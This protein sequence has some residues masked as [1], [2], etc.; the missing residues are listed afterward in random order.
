MPR[1]V[2]AL[3][4]LLVLCHIGAGADFAAPR[5]FE[6]R[7]SALLADADARATTLLQD[8]MRGALRPGRDRRETADWGSAA[9]LHRIM[10]L[11]QPMAQGMVH[12][13]LAAEMAQANFSSL[14]HSDPFFREAASDARLQRMAR[15]Q[16]TQHCKDVRKEKSCSKVQKMLRKYLPEF[17]LSKHH[18][19]SGA[20]NNLKHR[21]YGSTPMPL[22]R[23]LGAAYDQPESSP[24]STGAGGQPLPGSR[25][26]SNSLCFGSQDQDQI[27]TMMGVTWGQL[28]DHDVD[29]TCAGNFD[30]NQSCSG[31][32]GSS[33]ETKACFPIAVATSDT[34]LGCRAGNCIPMARSCPAC[35]KGQGSREQINQ[36][37]SYHDASNV[38]GGPFGA[39]DTY[40]KGLADLTTGKMRVQ[41]SSSN[42]DLLPQATGNP[43]SCDGTCFQGGDAR[44]NEVPVLTAFH[45]IWVR[46]HN[47]L[48]PALK[49]INPT[50]TP[51]K[52][53]LE[54]R[55]IVTALHQ[56][57]TYAEFVPLLLGSPLESYKYCPETDASTANVFATASFR[58]AHSAI[59][60]NFNLADDQYM[61]LTPLSVVD[62][63]FDTTHIRSPGALDNLL[64]G[65]A[66]Q[67]AFKV[68]TKFSDSL[69]NRMFESSH[70]DC[71]LDLLS[72]N[73]QR[74]RDHGLPSYN[75]WRQLV[76]GRC[77]LT[78]GTVHSFDDLKSE[79]S[80]QSLASLKAVY[81]D[82]DDIDL[83]AG[84]LAETA[85]APSGVVGPTFWC[86]NKIQLENFRKGD[87]LFYEN[88][89][90]F[91]YDQVTE[92]KKMTLATIICRNSDDITRMPEHVMRV[93]SRSTFVDCAGLPEMD[94][95]M[96][97]EG[98]SC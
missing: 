18:A 87:R 36:I 8:G 84:G 38:Y 48:V 44:A 98:S 31:I 11:P 97:K 81:D 29:L 43:D 94:L 79:M 88:P 60:E 4:A 6:V 78:S 58:Y 13:A 35:I 25:E 62:G 1:L 24:R 47:R 72:L 45:T 9:E 75:K 70:G 34:E 19:F 64:R 82:V 92:I 5:A 16:I 86:L 65:M 57:I 15:E 10:G 52:L 39:G 76:R 69:R 22:G 74:G 32:C 90:V 66:V 71:G 53:Y 89:G 17:D 14:V 41:K 27:F 23:M 55:K 61:P 51:T 40:W 56:H 42:T 54:A 33:Q 77:Q 68:D 30:K 80:S 2:A 3:S 26:V 83:Y 37:T 93:D 50:W 46:E 49:S 91:S 96:W 21:S 67:K 12:A 95:R 73:I 63:Y 7:L 20:C 28:L 59:T 85:Y